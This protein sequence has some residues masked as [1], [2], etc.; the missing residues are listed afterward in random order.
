MSL[1]RRE[2]LFIS[3]LLLATLLLDFFP[4]RIPVQNIVWSSYS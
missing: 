1:I 4:V 3:I 2:R